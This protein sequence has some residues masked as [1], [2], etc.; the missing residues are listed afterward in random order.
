[1]LVEQARRL[2]AVDH[3]CVNSPACCLLTTP[4]ST[5]P[6]SKMASSI[7][8]GFSA[9]SMQVGT[10]ST[11]IDFRRSRLIHSI[12]ILFKIRPISVLRGRLVSSCSSFLSNPCLHALSHH[13]STVPPGVSHHVVF[14]RFQLSLQKKPVHK[15]RW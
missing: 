2:I 7:C 3:S 11:V 1:M 14:R 10:V 4:R 9:E 12:A 8:G 6:H 5:P 13:S 15:L